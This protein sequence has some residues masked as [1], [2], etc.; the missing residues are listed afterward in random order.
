MKKFTKSQVKKLKK[1]WKELQEL[2]GKHNLEIHALQLTMCSD[3]G[4]DNLDF[5]WRYGYCGIGDFDRKYELITD[6]K[7][8]KK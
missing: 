4:I 2:E 7:L 8:E 3:V 6:N 1:H 5:L